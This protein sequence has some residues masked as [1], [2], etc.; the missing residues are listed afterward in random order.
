MVVYEELTACERDAVRL[1]ALLCSDLSV[2]AGV[3]AGIA[4]GVDPVRVWLGL[5]LCGDSTVAVHV[6]ASP[7]AAPVALAALESRRSPAIRRALAGNEST[8][9]PVLARLARGRDT[10]EV[11][12]AN[13]AAP[14]VLRGH[15]RWC[16]RRW[17]VAGRWGR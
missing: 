8:P 14:W 4:C 13:A 17:R 2:D 1:A 10:A 7:W 6:A 9:F 5:A 16:T 12:A 15:A 11:V 3:L